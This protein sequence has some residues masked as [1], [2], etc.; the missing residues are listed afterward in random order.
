MV[1]NAGT[2]LASA[3]SSAKSDAREQCTKSRSATTGSAQDGANGSSGASA[4]RHADPPQA[5][6]GGLA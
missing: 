6:G 2:G 1:P 4:P 3:G 5:E